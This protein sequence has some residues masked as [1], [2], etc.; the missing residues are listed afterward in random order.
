MHSL[1]ERPKEGE[2]G[3]LELRKQIWVLTYKL[4]MILVE[5]ESPMASGVAKAQEEAG[6][7]T[8]V[9]ERRNAVLR[10]GESHQGGRGAGRGPRVQGFPEV[11]LV[12]E[13]PV[14]ARNVDRSPLGL[15][16]RHQAGARWPGTCRLMGSCFGHLEPSMRGKTTMAEGARRDE[17][18]RVSLGRDAKRFFP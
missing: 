6:R 3:G 9:L 4:D 12:A 14:E 8:E 16:M 15:T 11:R 5:Q 18:G 2:T 10:D 17:G 7:P 1:R 13:L